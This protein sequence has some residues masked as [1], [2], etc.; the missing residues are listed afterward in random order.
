MQKTYI[1]IFFLCV[2]AQQLG[3]LN[4]VSDQAGQFSLHEKHSK[5]IK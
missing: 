5:N 2:L 3:G 1:C 4:S